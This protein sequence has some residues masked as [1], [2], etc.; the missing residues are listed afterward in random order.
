MYNYAAAS[1]QRKTD[2]SDQNVATDRFVSQK[3]KEFPKHHR[4]QFA[5]AMLTELKFIWNVDNLELPFAACAYVKQYLET[6]GGKARQRCEKGLAT[7]HKEP[8]HG[9]AE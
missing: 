3:K 1:Y 9:I 5:F 8:T 4:I 6:D 7:H 2:K